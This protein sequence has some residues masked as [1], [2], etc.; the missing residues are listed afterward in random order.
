MY[1]LQQEILIQ[2]GNARESVGFYEIKTL[3][4][5][6]LYDLRI[7]WKLGIKKISKIDID[8]SQMTWIIL[9]RKSSQFGLHCRTR[10]K[11]Q[12]SSAPLFRKLRTLL[13]ISTVRFVAKGE[14]IY[15]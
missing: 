6:N 12:R 15:K 1:S 14:K 8:V 7:D 9:W 5:S 13:K 10:E 3:E 2:A 4:S 11:G